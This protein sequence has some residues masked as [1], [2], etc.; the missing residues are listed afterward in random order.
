MRDTIFAHS[1]SDYVNEV[2]EDAICAINDG[3]YDYANDFDEA[4][5][6][7]WID[8]AITGNGS[9][10]YYFD[11]VSA[12][13]AVR[14]MVFDEEARA[15]VDDNF[16]DGSFMHALEEG[17]EV[18]DVT[19]RCVAIGEAYTRIRDAYDARGEEE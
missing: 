8:D 15:W 9:G 18:L 5:E 11:S 19:F 14:D 7:M 2:A 16:G 3:E 10:S 13:E 17:P 4:Y 1:V 12:R 6:D